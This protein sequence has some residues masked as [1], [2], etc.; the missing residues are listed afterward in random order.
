MAGQDESVQNLEAFI[1]LVTQTTSE[2]NDQTAE[3]ETAQAELDRLSD[4]VDDSLGGLGDTIEDGLDALGDEADRAAAALADVETAGREAAESRLSQLSSDLGA[5]AE[6][7]E[8]RASGARERIE[9]GFDDL[10]ADGLQ[11]FAEVLHELADDA[12]GARGE[13]EAGFGELGEAISAAE[14]SLREAQD[15]ATQALDEAASSASQEAAEVTAAGQQAASDWAE[16]RAE[17]EA[18]AAEAQSA[19]A[20]AY[21][22]WTEHV[23]QQGETALAAAREALAGAE[24]AATESAGLLDEAARAASEDALPEMAEEA[25]EVTSAVEP[26]DPLA[27][28]LE[29][30]VTELVVVQ[31]VVDQ[32]AKLLQEIGNG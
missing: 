22:E 1:A 28:A 9:E 23:R 14:A 6:R 18:D 27:Q 7:A 24:Q 11:A 13:A 10:K 3:V 15:D 29:P 25:G 12:D 31:S 30:M 21:T 19:L 16:G 17:L 8:S 20:D 5:A 32:I 2:L 26:G 4:E